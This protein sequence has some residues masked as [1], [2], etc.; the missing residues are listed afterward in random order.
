MRL[1]IHGSCFD[2]LC[3]WFNDYEHDEAIFLEE[4][5]Q[6]FKIVYCFF[7][8]NNNTGYVDQFLV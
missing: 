8:L 7:M 6:Y 3:S 1:N 2:L 4:V 5:C